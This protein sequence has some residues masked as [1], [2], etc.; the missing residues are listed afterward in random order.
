MAAW[1]LAHHPVV[2]LN[3]IVMTLHIAAILVREVSIWLVKQK[4]IAMKAQ[5]TGHLDLH[6][7][8]VSVWSDS[9]RTSASQATA[10]KL[11]SYTL[12][13]TPVG[14][15]KCTYKEIIRHTANFTCLLF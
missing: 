10:M 8:G 3:L 15:V 4:H 11:L 7:A 12:T 9:Y 14:K 2:F 5:A 1:I 13:Q 6:T